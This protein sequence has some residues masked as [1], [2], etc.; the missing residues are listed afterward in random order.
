MTNY[1]DVERYIEKVPLFC[2]TNVAKNKANAEYLLQGIRLLI[3]SRPGDSIQQPMDFESYI[4]GGPFLDERAPATQWQAYVW[5]LHGELSQWHKTEEEEPLSEAEILHYASARKQVKEFYEQ[6]K[7]QEEQETAKLMEERR[8][9][10]T[11][12]SAQNEDNSGTADLRRFQLRE[13][14]IGRDE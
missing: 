4:S 12:R 1:F 14:R 13:A 10:V 11:V 6:R 2:V 3:A 8:V 7:M 5:Y 9:R